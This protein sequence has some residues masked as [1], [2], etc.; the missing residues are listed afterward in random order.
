MIKEETLKSEIEV[1]IHDL[2]EILNISGLTIPPYQRPY[3]WTEKQLEP[4][5]HDLYKKEA[6]KPLIM[7]GIILHKNKDDK[8]NIV[9]GQQ[10]LI[11]FAILLQLLEYPVHQNFLS[12]EFPH[13]QS[14]ENIWN[15]TRFIKEIIGKR[16]K[17]T[18]LEELKNILFIVVY[19]PKLDDAFAFFDSQNTRGKKLEDFDILKAHHLRYIDS[20]ELAT[21]CAKNWE[22]IQ[23]DEHIGLGLLLETLL[24]KTRK[25]SR[26]DT[27][28]V[29]IKEEFKSQRTE[30][31]AA[32]SYLLNKYQQ[33]PL[34]K[35]W[36]Y[37]WK[38]QSLK[39][40]SSGKNIVADSGEFTIQQDA[41]KYL[42]FQLTQSIEGGELF[43]WYTQKYYNLHK[44][45]FQNKNKNC[46]VFFN[47]LVDKLKA[48][49]YN[50]GNTYV[51][52]IFE[53]AILFYIDKFGYEQLDKVA[54]HLFFSI[55]WLRMNKY[56]VQYNSVNKYIREEFNPF[57]LIHEAGF[58]DYMLKN[59]D[60]FL[61][62]KYKIKIKNENGDYIY[63]TVRVHFYEDFIDFNQESIFKKYNLFVPESILH[64]LKTNSNG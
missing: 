59:C 51:Y 27:A 14:I 18:I 31:R 30:K 44:E 19:A 20:N 35:E 2:Q 22:L 21:D 3:S 56:S 45:V 61:E 25:W 53:A 46:S 38:T 50:S 40:N 58:I 63:N 6:G 36:T 29:D 52:Q 37:E 1:R 26:N 17:G 9:D 47:E 62:G 49:N 41:L 15:N 64:I 10:R 33:A 24:G 55:Y 32:T 57:S 48:Y 8:I 34:F 11:S 16:G 23:K 60:D 13:S 5:L 54:A 12:H 7:G 28:G 43:F 4:L 42:P 39:L